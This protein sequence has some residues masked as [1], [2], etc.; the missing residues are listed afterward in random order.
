MFDL[1]ANKLA[2]FIFPRH[3]P[4]KQV[5]TIGLLDITA[6]PPSTPC[7]GLFDLSTNKLAYIIFTRHY[8]VKQVHSIGLLDL[9]V[10]PGST[11]CIGLFDLSEK[12][13]WFYLSTTLPGQTSTQYWFVGYYR[14]TS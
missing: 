10:K 2:D 1:S 11:Q 6:E 4:V 12:F 9:T 14:G 7:I 8:P 3:C 5:H 13:G